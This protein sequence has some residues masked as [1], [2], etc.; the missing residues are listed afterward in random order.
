[1]NTHKNQNLNYDVSGL[2]TFSLRLVVGWTY[3]SAL[4]RRMVLANKLDPDEAGYIGEKFNH[5]LPNALG[6]K[7][8][9]EY[10]VTHP[11]T[12]WLTMLIFTL[13]EGVVGL[14]IMLGLFT[15]IMSIGV[16][17]LAL[18]ILLGA[19]WIGTT[20]LDEWQIGVLGIAT[21][22]TIYFTGGG[23]FSV[24]YWLL[25]KNF[26]FTKSNWFGFA[27]SGKLNLN[28]SQLKKIQ[29]IG[30]L[31]IVGLTLFTN[32]YFHGG[33]FGK[34]HN[35]S[36][37]PKLEITHA[38]VSPNQ[39]EFT[40]FRTEGV[41]VYGS[42]LI[43]ISLT[44]SNGEVVFELKGDQLAALPPHSINNHYIAKVKPGKHSLVIPLGSKANL[45]LEDKQFFPSK[46]EVYT[47]TLTDISGV[48]WDKNIN[49]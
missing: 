23:I 41:D 45:Q 28:L 12:L 37:K 22:F 32:Q 20:C 7:P 47:L 14:C 36:V 26:S 40:V 9:I 49:W 42:F 38:S 35:K 17:G 8:M 48:E 34:L 3:F 46:N 39:L 44:K 4:W 31:L 13:V 10:L 24:D 30:A 6:I 1:M 33:L 15:R 21:G 5:F 29:G 18:G 25:K 43:G 11:E 2:F 19:G 27:G 16:F